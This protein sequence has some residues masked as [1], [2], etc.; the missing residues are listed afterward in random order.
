ML[1][2]SVYILRA[3]QA[4]IIGQLLR[5]VRRRTDDY[6]PRYRGST[7][8]FTITSSASSSSILRDLIRAPI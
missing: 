5:L 2:V 3:N 6:L 4:T 8:M 1:S 7:S